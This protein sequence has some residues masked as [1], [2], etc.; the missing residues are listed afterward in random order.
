[1]AAIKILPL[2]PN[3]LFTDKMGSLT[4]EAYDFLYTMV[5]RLGT[6]LSSLDAASLLGNTW[7]APGTIGSVTPSTGSF[8]SVTTPNLIV[9][10]AKNGRATLVAGTAV[11]ANTAVTA[12]SNIF[13]TSNVDGGTLGGLRISSIVPGTSFTIKSTSATD[14]STVAWMIVERG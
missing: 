7:T 12:N 4:K 6:S 9:A 8:T 5:N 13:I 11:V 3:M 14:T 1:M 2:R 10:A